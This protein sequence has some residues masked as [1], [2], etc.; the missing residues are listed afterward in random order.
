MEDGFVGRLGLAV[1]L[2]MRHA[3]ET[4]LATQIIEVV[5]ELA[6]VKLP[7]IV[8]NYGT[9]DAKL[10]D[11]VA[12]YK[13]IHLS[14]GYGFDSLGFDP[15]GEI[16]DY[17]KKVLVLACSLAKRAKDVHAPRSEMGGD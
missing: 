15:L 14:G 10:G 9:R 13:F 5:R 1:S 6:S 16:V 4:G 7:I 11:D 3:R 17:H 12:P 2:R 8:E